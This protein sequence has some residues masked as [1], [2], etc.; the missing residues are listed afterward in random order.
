[1]AALQ[2]HLETPE[3]QNE[4]VFVVETFGHISKIM[5]FLGP[6][7]ESQ[8]NTLSLRRLLVMMRGIY[9]RQV[10]YQRMKNATRSFATA[11]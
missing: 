7:C 11:G 2:E 3:P 6:K 9:K 1:M 5:R 8:A 10:F 4:G